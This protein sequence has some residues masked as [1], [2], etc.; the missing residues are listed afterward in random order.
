MEESSEESRRELTLNVLAID[1]S[2]GACSVAMACERGGTWDLTTR[3]EAMPRGHSERLMPM[4]REVVDEAGIELAG[5]RLICVT[6]GPGTFTGVRIGLAAAKGL[7]LATQADLVGESSLAL[8][9]AGYLRANEADYS[10]R[11]VMV[12]VD[13]RRNQIYFQ[14]FANNG[15]AIADPVVLAPEDAASGLGEGT[16]VVGSGASMVAE[17]A[18]CTGKVVTIAG[19]NLQPD[20]R[21]LVK[22]GLRAPRISGTISPL[23]LRP[24]D[25]KPQTRSRLGKANQ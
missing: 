15:I 9:A 4:I 16:L 2:L 25:A 5:L 7:A 6:V 22:L 1:T 14:S 18:I 13:A 12:A 3:F 10:Q 11:D 23:Y 24:P 8:I 21:D 20:A 19:E 17:A